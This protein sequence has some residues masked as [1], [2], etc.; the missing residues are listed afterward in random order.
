M[1]P[2]IPMDYPSAGNELE[3]L[4]GGL[5]RIRLTF[6]WK[7]GGLGSTELRTTLG[8]SAITLGGLLKHL[9]LCEDYYF[10]YLLLGRDLGEPWNIPAADE[11]DWAWTSAA[12]DTPAQ[13][14]AWWHQSVA[15]SRHAVE[16][17][18]EGDG[19]DQLTARANHWGNTM[20][21]RRIIVDMNE[22]YARHTGHADLIRESIDGLVGEDPPRE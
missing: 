14:E 9:A 1:A 12:D 21:L 16:R 17:A 18:L 15:R 13:L 20:N 2:T 5:E 19:L 4:H 3:S 10:T 8:P 22:E 7:C 11:P 6:I